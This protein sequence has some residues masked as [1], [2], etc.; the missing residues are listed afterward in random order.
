MHTHNT[1]T[2]TETHAR[3]RTHTPTH[4]HCVWWLRGEQLELIRPRSWGWA[5]TIW[6]NTCL[7]D[8]PQLKG[9]NK[10]S[11]NDSI[12]VCSCICGYVCMYTRACMCMHLCDSLSMTFIRPTLALHHCGCVW[13]SLCSRLESPS[14]SKPGGALIK[15]K[16]VSSHHPH[17]L[18]AWWQLHL[19]CGPIR[20]GSRNIY[21]SGPC[22]SK[23]ITPVIVL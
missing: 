12:C 2:H 9:H 11:L 19:C 22:R 18:S 23:S 16:S 5:V 13:A 4:T 21:R 8:S 15:P 10:W 1:Q 20:D 14:Y 6:R 3:V 17:N 7:P